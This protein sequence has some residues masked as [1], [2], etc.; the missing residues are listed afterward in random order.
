MKKISIHITLGLLLS[1]FTVL[2]IFTPSLAQEDTVT[3]TD[4]FDDPELEGWGHTPEV[5]VTDG[6]LQIY[7]GQFA[8]RFGDWGDFKLTLQTK[9]SGE[10]E[11]V[12]GYH[13]R[14]EGRYVLH[15]RTN[16]V[17]LVREVT[18]PF[19][20]LERA[21]I[22]GIAIG[23]W[24]DVG[25]ALNDGEHEIS[26]NQELVISVSET[27][28]LSPGPFILHVTGENI[29][30]FDNLTITGQKTSFIPEGE[31]GPD[32]GEPEPGMEGES[33]PGQEPPPES[34][35]GGV[36][37]TTSGAEAP[38][39]GDLT[40]FEEFFASQATPFELSTFAINLLLAVVTSFILSRVY[41]YWGSSLSNRRVF[42]ANFMLMTVTTTFIIL[43]V[44]SSVALSLGLVGALSIVR[45]RAAVK[46]P[47][48]LAYLFF[49]IG[50]GIGLG[51][52]QRLITLLTM[53]VAILIIGLMRLF[54]NTKADVNLHL[55]V[56]SNTP[57]KVDLEQIMGILEK[58]CSKLKLLRFDENSETVEASF[59]IEFKKVS[60]LNQ[61]KAELQA[62]S[63]T[64]NISFLDNKGIW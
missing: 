35:P 61:T 58:H 5:V 54:R 36:P 46:E 31:P 59:V 9:F 33:E 50:L 18:E 60:N 19:T 22:T 7:S 56:S 24:V 62:L 17:V 37:P 49:A 38:A 63:G 28:P 6:V 26:I 41:I 53:V 43:V 8:E 3:E 16:E 27:D 15:V 25:I 44:R 4:T 10:G 23:E 29:G 57:N 2:F 14:E 42:A 51:D 11:I 30:E 1:L 48:E 64:M 20:D 34:E 39:G 47:E 55:T 13:F 32:Q 12:I 52:N 45:F 40:L 21:D